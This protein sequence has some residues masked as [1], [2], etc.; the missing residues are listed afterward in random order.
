[1]NKNLL[2]LIIISILFTACDL[3]KDIELDLPSYENKIVVECYLEPGQP[4]KL[5]LTESVSYFT[6]PQAPTVNNALVIITYNGIKDTL[7]FIPQF[8]DLTGKF[9]NY[10]SETIVPE[11]YDGVFTLYV[12]DL[13]GREVTGQTKIPVPP[14][15]NSV[16]FIYN[17]ADSL[18]FAYTK[19]NDVDIN[20]NDYYRYLVTFDNFKGAE[21]V[22]LLLNDRV[23]STDNEIAV[24]FRY[25]LKKGDFIILNIY[26]MNEDY[27]RYLES[28][29]LAIDANGNPF[30]Q[31]ASIKS[32][33]QGGI[34]IFTGLNYDRKEFTVK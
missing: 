5:T 4:Y 11:D 34:G 6:E 20:A 2:Q 31:P 30:G 29:N 1:M 23:Q 27:Y 32:N 9:Y 28:I 7:K 15:I 18:A 13:K 26:H 22:D 3:E 14:T 25:K 19:F 10:V 8:D 17:S 12:R 21:A 33:V 24:G 16:E